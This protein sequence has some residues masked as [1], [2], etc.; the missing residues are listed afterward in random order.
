MSNCLQL[1][2]VAWC[3]PK[4]HFEPNTATDETVWRFSWHFTT[5]TT[6]QTHCLFT[7]K[8]IDHPHPRDSVISNVFIMEWMYN[9]LHVPNDQT[10]T[11][12]SNTLLERYHFHQRCQQSEEDLSTFVN[13]VLELAKTCDFG[14]QWITFVR[15]RV[16]FGLYDDDLKWSIIRGDIDPSLTDVMNAY[17]LHNLNAGNIIEDALNERFMP[18][19]RTS[20]N[21]PTTIEYIKFQFGSYRWMRRCA[22][23]GNFAVAG[24]PRSERYGEKTTTNT[25][26]NIRNM[27]I[28]D[29]HRVDYG[30]HGQQH[31]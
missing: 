24:K 29:N 4:K 9:H 17:D 13:D 18:G 20:I 31:V 14:D 25:A 11:P 26:R 22:W 8:N 30:W 10:L 3:N 15:D 27:S 2:I 6:I 19:S 12:T 21:C 28:R 5:R 1:C 16:V 7:Y 23:D